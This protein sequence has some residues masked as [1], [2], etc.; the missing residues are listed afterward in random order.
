MSVYK[1]IGVATGV[2]VLATL[3]SS[4]HAGAQSANTTS[5][6]AVQPSAQMVTDAQGNATAATKN[7]WVKFAGAWYYYV[8]GS[9]YKGWLDWNGGRY[10]LSP[11]MASN[12]WTIG[13]QDYRFTAS[14]TLY[15]GW[16]N[17]GGSWQYYKQGIAQSNWLNLGGVWYYLQNGFMA[18]NGFLPIDGVYYSFDASGAM[19]T[20][21]VKS[22]K[23]WYYFDTIS[24]AMHY[25]WLQLGQKWYYLKPEAR[26]LML[27]GKQFIDGRW[28]N[29]DNSGVWLGYF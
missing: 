29:F 22:G 27:T 21:W 13:S 9:Q 20:G 17:R 10:Y 14:G 5:S 18:S 26:G 8:N 6:T 19:R 1:N 12:D 11:V 24:G 25:G 3:G 7:G 4:A 16:L 15:N 2:I 28:S 23:Y